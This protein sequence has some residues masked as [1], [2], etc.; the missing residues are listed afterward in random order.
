METPL[1]VA[2]EFQQ[3]H[4]VNYLCG[5]LVGSCRVQVARSIR[6]KAEEKIGLGYLIS[7]S[8]KKLE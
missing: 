6:R 7:R 2:E 1:D 8:D 4:I 5:G 3:R